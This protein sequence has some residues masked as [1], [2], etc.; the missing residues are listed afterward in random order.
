MGN[1]VVYAFLRPD[2]T[3]F[4]IGMGS[5]NR[6]RD[7]S[8]GSRNWRWWEEMK[9]YKNDY[10]FIIVDR[11]LTPGMAFDLERE[12]IKEFGRQ[13]IDEYG[14]LTNISEG[15]PWFG[16]NKNIVRAYTLDGYFCREFE[17]TH[18]AEKFVNKK[19]GSAN[20][21]NCCHGKKHSI[22][23]HQWQFKYK[24]GDLDFIGPVKREKNLGGHNTS[25]VKYRDIPTGLIFDSMNKHAKFL[26]GDKWYRGAENKKICRERREK[27]DQI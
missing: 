17:S 7:R 9:K 18:D 15:G 27:I 21:S 23:N 13:D 25:P 8:K 6:A 16:T 5:I 26:L 3:P 14:I 19:S 4:Y 10:K 11:S 22:Y 2:D 24:V 1:K 12:L 20:I